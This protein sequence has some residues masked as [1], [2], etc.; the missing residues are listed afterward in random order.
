MNGAYE[1]EDG[2]GGSRDH[3]LKGRK[4]YLVIDP[5]KPHRPPRRHGLVGVYL[6][7]RHGSGFFSKKYQINVNFILLLSKYIN[8]VVNT[9][10]C[11]NCLFFFF[12]FGFQFTVCYVF[13]LSVKF[14]FGIFD[15][16]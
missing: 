14:I 15:P 6:S 4:T 16:W 2:D 13:I 10:I 5:R 9:D 7:V 3:L 11:R 8:Y 1:V 12:Y